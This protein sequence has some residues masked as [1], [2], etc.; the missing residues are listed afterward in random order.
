VNRFRAGGAGFGVLAAARSVDR[1][2]Q[3]KLGGEGLFRHVSPRN[4]CFVPLLIAI[5][6]RMLT[7]IRKRSFLNVRPGWGR[8]HH[9][10]RRRKIICPII[11]TSPY[12]RTARH[13]TS[14]FGRWSPYSEVPQ[15]HMQ[16][17]VCDLPLL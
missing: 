1:A 2:L 13:A 14:R 15:L 7:V 8:Q 9:L 16:R 3:Q 11:L 5:N 4:H 12:H 10:R 17:V 6:R